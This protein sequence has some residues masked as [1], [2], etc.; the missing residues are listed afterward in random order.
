ME[1]AGRVRLALLALLAAG[2]A[3]GYQ[4]KAAL[5]ETFGPAYPRPNIGQ[6][7]VTLGRLEKTGLVRGTAVDQATRPNKRVYEITD[8]GREALDVWRDG[9]SVEV[10]LRDDFFAKLILAPPPGPTGRRDLINSQRRECVQVM[11]GL[12]RLAADHDRDDRTAQ[13][14]VEGALLHLQADLDW[15]ERCQEELA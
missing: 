8:A 7:Y 13:L 10:R 12:S 2:P 11:R 6:V 9:P 15:L 3:H 1:E 4:L 14:L 5:E